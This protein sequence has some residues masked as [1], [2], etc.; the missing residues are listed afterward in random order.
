VQLVAHADGNWVGSCQF[1]RQ[2]GSTTKS[3]TIN[4][5]PAD[6]HA[7]PANSRPLKALGNEAV[8]CESAHEANIAGRI[9][10]GWF[11]ITVTNVPGVTQKLYTD[12]KP[13]DAYRASL[14]EII[15]EQ[16]VGNL[17]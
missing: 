9:R 6:S 12:A 1:T 10:N 17:Y 16:V 7:C 2:D 15:A 13:P 3:L 14:L 8:R 5:G 4:V 11:V